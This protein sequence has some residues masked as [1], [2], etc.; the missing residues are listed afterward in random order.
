MWNIKRIASVITGSLGALGIAYLGLSQVWA[1]PYGGEVEQTAGIIVSCVS[2]VLAVITG[3]TVAADS[4]AAK[5]T[6]AK[7]EATKAASV[8][9]EV[10]P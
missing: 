9:G 10:A 6:A 7:E 3:S 8:K 4:K 1:L 5:A 2:A